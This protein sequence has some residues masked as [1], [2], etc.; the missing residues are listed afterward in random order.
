MFAST[1]PMVF[2]PLTGHV[3]KF[4]ANGL[5]DVL[6]RLEGGQRLQVAFAEPKALHWFD[7][8]HADSPPELIEQARQFLA[9][10]LA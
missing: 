10:Q 3:P 4:V 9:T 2:V 7:G 8:G 5:K 1:D 6:V